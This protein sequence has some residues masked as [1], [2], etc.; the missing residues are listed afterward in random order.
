MVLI[1]F[2]VAIYCKW[3]G[4]IDP[5]LAQCLSCGFA[6]IAR[7]MYIP[8]YTVRDFPLVLATV[9]SL[10]FYPWAHADE[11]GLLYIS[12]VRVRSLD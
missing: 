6:I 2:P 4:Q 8:S 9:C 10:L 7:E 5:G 12:P 1:S 3:G 11:G